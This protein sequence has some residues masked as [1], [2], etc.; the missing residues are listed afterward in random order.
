MEVS[1]FAAGAPASPGQSSGGAS[2]HLLG[3]PQRFEALLQQP[4]TEQVAGQGSGFRDR[5]VDD[6]V[7]PA[8]AS[9]RPVTLSS[10]WLSFGQEFSDDFK[11]QRLEVSKLFDQQAS[12]PFMKRYQAQLDALLKVQE[13]LTQ[14]TL[15]MKGI[16]LSSQSAQQ[17]FKMQG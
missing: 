6:L 9:S 5:Y 17:L 2:P 10:E 14:Y 3:Q 15:V 16:E 12:S 1:L 13:S 7:A 4:P 11:T 8:S